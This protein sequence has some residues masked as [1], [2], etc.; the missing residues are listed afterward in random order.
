MSKTRLRGID[1]TAFE[2]LG[3]NTADWTSGL[4]HRRRGAVMWPSGQGI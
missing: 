4:D 2:S 3:E 1:D